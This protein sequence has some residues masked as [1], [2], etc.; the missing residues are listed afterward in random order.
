MTLVDTSHPSQT[1]L[2]SGTAERP[3]TREAQA[4]IDRYLGSGDRLAALLDMVSKVC[5]VSIGLILVAWALNI[6][7]GAVHLL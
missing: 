1:E 7:P 2:T 5:A 6:L 3:L 4:S